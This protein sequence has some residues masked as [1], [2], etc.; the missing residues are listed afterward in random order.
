M[1]CLPGRMIHLA[2]SIGFNEA[3]WISER[4]HPGGPLAFLTEQQG[5]PIAIVEGGGFTVATILAEGLLF[6]ALLLIILRMFCNQAWLSNTAG[7]LH[8]AGQPDFGFPT[9]SGCLIAWRIH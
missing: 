3:A 7:M 8:E 6:T 5:R 2:C 1:T 9:L 4:G